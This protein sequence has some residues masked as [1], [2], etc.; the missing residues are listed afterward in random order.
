MDIHELISRQQIT[1]VLHSY[2]RAMD[3]ID[4]DLALACWHPGGTDTHGETY[5]GSA[6]GFVD[7]VLPLHER[8]TGTRHTITNILITLDGDRAQTECYWTVRMFDDGRP[9]AER[10]ATAVG[11]YL[12][13]FERIDGRWAIRHRESVRERFWFDGAETAAA[14]PLPTSE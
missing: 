10:N 9:L 14:Q 11:R 6:E 2:C 4:R 5:S 1:D 7:W 3:R 13:R 8:V 12:D